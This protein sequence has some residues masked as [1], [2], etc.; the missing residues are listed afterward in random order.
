LCRSLKP[1]VEAFVKDYENKVKF[2]NLNIGPNRE[3]LIELGISG[4]PSFL[5]FK[6][7]HEISTL[8]GR[9]ILMDEIMDHTQKLLLS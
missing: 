6:N 7:G 3:F 5:F 8:A 4:L 2:L 9:N 1:Q